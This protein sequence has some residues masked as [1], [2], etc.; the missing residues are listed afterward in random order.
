ML[1][2]AL[3]M[4][5]GAL[6]VLA[7]WGIDI[8]MNKIK[9]SQV[10]GTFMANILGSFLAGYF[11]CYLTEISKKPQNILIQFWA[12]YQNQ[13]HVIFITGFCG[14]LTT[15]SA[16]SLQLFELGQP[17]TFF[18]ALMLAALHLLCGPIAVWIGFQVRNYFS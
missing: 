4:I 10:W 11:T 15:F 7:R 16:L 3:V 13:W 18:R 1:L 14:G 2:I 6:G 17:N 5:A 8:L 12:N 9:W